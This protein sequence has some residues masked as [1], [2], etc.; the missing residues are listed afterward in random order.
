MAGAAV[1]GQLPQGTAIVADGVIGDAEWQDAKILFVNLSESVRVKVLAKH[2]G[3]N[4]LA[5]FISDLNPNRTLFMPELVVDTSLDRAVSWQADDWWFHV[6]A[7]DCQS[8][9]RWGDYSTCRVVQPDWVGVPNYPMN[10]PSPALIER[11]EIRIPLSKLGL[12]AGDTCGLAFTVEFVSDQRA[13]WPPTA[14]MS[15]PRTWAEVILCDGD[16]LVT[17]EARTSLGAVKAQYR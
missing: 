1:T 9:G 11:F 15:Q 2:D 6:S 16:C 8:N 10:D 13:I 5:A 3:T 12:A 14:G 17:S 4:L 7:S